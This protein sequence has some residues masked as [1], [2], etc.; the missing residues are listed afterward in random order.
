TATYSSQPV[1]PAALTG[2]VSVIQ[3][4]AADAG[5]NV[6]GTEAIATFDLNLR[7]AT[8]PGTIVVSPSSFFVDKTDRR[9]L[10]TINVPLA[11]GSKVAVTA[12]SIST[13]VNGSYVGS[14][15]GAILGGATSPSG[16][17]W[18]V[19]TV[20]GGTVQCDYSPGT[21]TV[22][23]RQTK[24]VNIQVVPAN[25][26]G[27]ATT[28]TPLAIGTITLTGAAASEVAFTRQSLPVLT[29]AQTAQVIVHHVHDVRANLLPDGVN[30][31]LTSSAVTL[32]TPDG[33]CYYASVGGQITDGQVPSDSRFRLFPLAQGEVIATYSPA[34]V[35]T[36]PGDVKTATVSVTVADAAGNF[37]DQHAIGNA[38]IQ[39]LGPAHGTP[40][41]VTP[42]SLLADGGAHVATATFGPILHSY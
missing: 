15:G 32:I 36:Q 9:S 37:I 14:A 8:D 13:I 39:L 2:A 21:I 28:Q 7:A 33:C 18:A 29:V 40:G 24:T 5:G 30:V 11:D 26:S 41:S 16:S 25:A 27:V 1:M 17:Q 38:T 3:V 35:T 12:N 31:L 20:S 6:L 4:I 34:T 22:Q 19:F 23:N 42:T 10:V